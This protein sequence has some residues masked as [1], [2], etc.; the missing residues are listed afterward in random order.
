MKLKSGER[1]EIYNILTGQRTYFTPFHHV[2]YQTAHILVGY[3]SKHEI[4][5]PSTVGRRV[6]GDRLGGVAI[7]PNELPEAVG[8]FLRMR[9]GLPLMLT[10]GNEG[11]VTLNVP[12]CQ[13]PGCDYT[14]GLLHTKTE[15]V[16]QVVKLIKW[17]VDQYRLLKAGSGLAWMSRADLVSRLN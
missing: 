6:V 12:S 10:D 2:E 17:G 4:W 5:L 13:D 16:D 7:L 1:Y 14:C 9:K 15:T 3:A 8:A 11:M